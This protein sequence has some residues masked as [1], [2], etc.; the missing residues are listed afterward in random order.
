MNTNNDINCEGEN[1]SV[2][3]D[4]DEREPDHASGTSSDAPHV[5]EEPESDAI[6]SMATRRIEAKVDDAMDRLLQAF[7]DKIAYDES[8]Q[9]QID[10][11]HE[12]LR[13][14][15]SD[16]ISRTA[17]PLVREIIQIH[18]HI[19]KLRVALASGTETELQ[20]EKCLDLLESMQED[21]ALALAHNGVE[22]Y[23]ELATSF[24]ARRQRV[25]KRLNTTDKDLHGTIAERIRP[26]FE[27][28]GRIVAKES[29]S[30]YV[31]AEATGDAG[32]PSR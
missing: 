29:V 1:S 21:L 7:Q 5:P 8:K 18:D 19:G 11:L 28:N 15:Q 23:R 32:R 25:L 27:M 20:L 22:A 13:N 10:R 31:L 17:L 4:S 6:P 12:E 2:V 30:I 24:D 16:L 14:H 9:I 26:G 3:P